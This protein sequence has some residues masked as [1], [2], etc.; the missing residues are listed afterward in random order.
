M[1]LHHLA[2]DVKLFLGGCLAIK[3]LPLESIHGPP[4]AFSTGSP[5]RIGVESSRHRHHP[6]H[7]EWR[8]H[9]FSC[10]G[11]CGRSSAQPVDPATRNGSAGDCRL[12]RSDRGRAGSAH[13]IKPANDSGNTCQRRIEGRLSGIGHAPFRHRRCR[14]LYPCAPRI[15]SRSPT[16]P[17]QNILPRSLPGGPTASPGSH[18]RR[19]SY[20]PVR[21]PADPD[22]RPDPY[23]QAGHRKLPDR[24]R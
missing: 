3:V 2:Q 6:R 22:L 11:I 12:C 13:D 8:R 10:D 14:G 18:T 1:E 4:A 23:R 21:R 20:S 17:G 9:G 7:C 15:M 24:Y 5:R 19:H 16:R